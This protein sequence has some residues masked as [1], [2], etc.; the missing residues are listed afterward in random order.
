[1]FVWR[2]LALRFQRAICRSLQNLT[3]GAV[4]SGYYRPMSQVLQIRF[5]LLLCLIF[6]IVEFWHQ[7]H[8]IK[9][10]HNSNNCQSLLGFLLWGFQFRSLFIFR[11]KT[12]IFYKC[13]EFIVQWIENQLHQ[14]HIVV[15]SLLLAKRS[16]SS[17]SKE[18]SPIATQKLLGTQIPCHSNWWW[19]MYFINTVQ[20]F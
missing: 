3:Q 18:V 8:N 6:H 4:V 13:E 7:L 9:Q 11:S 10:S 19:F 5:S 17:V 14:A 1:M 20:R 15:R 12:L 2:F 16:C